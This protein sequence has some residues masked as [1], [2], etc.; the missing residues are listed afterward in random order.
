[1][2]TA[3]SHSVFRVC[4]LQILVGFPATAPELSPTWKPSREFE[5]RLISQKD[6]SEDGQRKAFSQQTDVYYHLKASRLHR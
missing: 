5:V 4:K 2:G 1:M 6:W 3:R